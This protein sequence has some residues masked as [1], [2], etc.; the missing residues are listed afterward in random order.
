[1][2]PQECD[3]VQVSLTNI[4][5]TETDEQTMLNIITT[6]W[7]IWKARN[8]LRF[9][10]KQW[11]VSQVHF[12]VRAYLSAYRTAHGKITG[13]AIQDTSG[14]QGHTRL[15]EPNESDPN[16]NVICQCS[17]M[18]VPRCYTDAATMPDTWPQLSRKAGLRIHITHPGQGYTIQVLAQ[19]DRCQSVLMAEAMAICLASDICSR[20]QI[21]QVHFHTDSK[22]LAT[23]L[24]DATDDQP[25]DW[26]IKVFTQRFLNTKEAIQ[27]SIH[28]IDRATQLTS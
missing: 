20:L 28:K 11:S 13:N 15:S 27:A 19:A 17:L 14:Q 21:Q 1:M 7:F 25:P 10:K 16:Q 6:M 8:E 4:I 26:R 3:G 24:N 22:V 2:L 23:F 18:Q 5:N 12:A 9:R